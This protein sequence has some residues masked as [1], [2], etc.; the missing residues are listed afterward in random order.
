MIFNLNKDSGIIPRVLTQ[1]LDGCV[2]GV[3]LS[4]PG[5]PDNPIIYANRAFEDITGY[6][7]KEVI[8]KNCRFLQNDDRKQDAIKI[9]HE[10]IKNKSE[11][12]VTLRNYRKNGELFYNH[13]SIKPL[14]D[15]DGS[16]LY[17]LG[18]QYD[19]TRHIEAQNEITSLNKQLDFIQNKSK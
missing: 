3:T 14:L 6:S 19:V 10:A 7:N 5:L 17:F 9:V 12:E 11:V 16:L 2:N 13:L 8:G 15:R 1:I 18:L 4:D